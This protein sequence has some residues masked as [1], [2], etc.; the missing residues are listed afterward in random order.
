MQAVEAVP[1]PDSPPPGSIAPRDASNT[2]TGVLTVLQPTHGWMRID[3]GELWRYRDLL[4]FLTWRE[5]S[6]RYKQTLLGFAWA[7]IQPFMT[8]VVFTVFLGKFAKV[9]S[10]NIPYPVFSYLGI[11]PWTYFANALTRSSGS[12]VANSSL[13]SKVYFPR[14]LIPLSGVLSALVDFVVALGVLVGLMLWYGIAPAP[15]ALLLL[16]L[17]ALT[18]LAALGIGMWLAALNVQYRDVQH[19]IPFL[20]QLWM[21]AT[22]VVYPASIVPEK[23]RLLFALNPMVGIIEAYRAA[24]LGRPL[25]WGGRGLSAVT[26]LALTAVGVWRFGKMER[27]FADIV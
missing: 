2:D 9:P 3:T 4:Y 10:D 12:L 7:V 15:T 23:W 8:M 17:V 1:P 16:P 18:A 21:Y 5:I 19:A 26:A 22:P 27:L 14:L 11:L 25:D 20:V 24:V 6:I 13:L